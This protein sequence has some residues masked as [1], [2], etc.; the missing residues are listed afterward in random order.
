MET[1]IVYITEEEKNIVKSNNS[2]LSLIREERHISGRDVDGGDTFEQALVFTDEL[3][4]KSVSERLGFIE[5]E[6]V[7]LK[8]RVQALENGF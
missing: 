3:V 6:N 7:E 2:E 1:R 4:E 8:A 5:N